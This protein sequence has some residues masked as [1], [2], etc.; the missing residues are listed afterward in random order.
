VLPPTGT[1]GPSSATP[2]SA[3]FGLLGLGG[4]LL[5][6]LTARRRLRG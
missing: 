1:G 6:L 4:G 5:A 3:M 2:L